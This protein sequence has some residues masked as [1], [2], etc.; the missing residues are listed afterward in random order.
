MS[1]HISLIDNVVSSLSRLPGIG[2]KTAAKYAMWCI[3][4]K[5][6]TNNIASALSS[7]INNVKL[8]KKCRNIAD[9]ELCSIC[10][11][12]TRNKDTICVVEDAENLLAI[13]SSKVYNGLYFILWG[14]ISP[15][16]GVSPENIGIDH[17]I[18]RIYKEDI[19]EVIM[20]ISSNTE[21]DLTAQYIKEKLRKSHAKITRIAYGVP[22]GININFV[23]NDTL[24][25]AFK[26]RQVF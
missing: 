19:K 20:V 13:E 1:F 18:D 3:S 12:S 17:L 26:G 16:Y 6:E 5:T 10:S 4:H 21:G 15:L 2:E 25:K 24:I 9:S 22:V 7:L 14:L 8:C 11:D 23:D